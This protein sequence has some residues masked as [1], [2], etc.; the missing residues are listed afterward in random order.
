[1]RNL[2]SNIKRQKSKE[3]KN[4]IQLIFKNEKRGRPQK[5]WISLGRIV[6][7]SSLP[8]FNFLLLS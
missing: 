1:M 3:L 7:K 2:D 6:G 5:N 4:D 8:Y